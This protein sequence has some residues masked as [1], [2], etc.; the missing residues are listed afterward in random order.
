MYS[1]LQPDSIAPAVDII[2]RKHERVV[3]VDLPGA[4]E[5]TIEVNAEN[6]LLTLTARVAAQEPQDM[7]VLYRGFE[8]RD[9]RRVFTLPDDVDRQRISAKCKHGVLHVTLPKRPEAQ[10]RRKQ[11]KVEK[12]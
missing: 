10:A 5:S 3:V 11:I 12:E 6:D 2:E 8:L 4:D 1:K 7:Q 9:Y